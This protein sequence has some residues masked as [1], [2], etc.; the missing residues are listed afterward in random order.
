MCQPLRFAYVRNIKCSLEFKTAGFLCTDLSLL[1][2]VLRWK[3]NA[4]ANFMGDPD[5]SAQPK[6]NFWLETTS[7]CFPVN[8]AIASSDQV[9]MAWADFSWPGSFRDEGQVHCGVVGR[10]C[11]QLLGSHRLQL[12]APLRYTY[13]ADQNNSWSIKTCKKEKGG[14]DKICFALTSKSK[15]SK[16]SVRTVWRSK[17]HQI[18]FS[19]ALC[20]KTFVAWGNTS[21]L[22]PEVMT[23]WSYYMSCIW[24]EAWYQSSNSCP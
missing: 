15:I 22:Q 17:L 9:I 20:S 3:L 6:V 13:T 12:P 24:N 8:L 14:R 19:H 7:F 4:L 11:T 23:A 18:Q 1:S 2:L 10:A 5:I 16:R 21:F